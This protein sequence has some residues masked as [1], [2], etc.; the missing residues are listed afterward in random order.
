MEGRDL[1]DGVRGHDVGG[2]GRKLKLVHV[3]IN[4]HRTKKKIKKFKN[5]F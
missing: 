4:L 3:R 5:I 1:E 2:G